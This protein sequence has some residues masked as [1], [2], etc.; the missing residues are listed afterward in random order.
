VDDDAGRVENPAE[1]GP[2]ARL[3]LEGRA[4]R[5]VAGREAGLDVLPS[6]PERGTGRGEHERASVLGDQRF[7]FLPAEELVDRGQLPQ[8]VGGGHERL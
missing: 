6:A 7:Q 5:E 1:A 4:L 2:Y 8:G 3:E